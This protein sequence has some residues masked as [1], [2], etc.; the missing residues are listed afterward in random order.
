MNKFIP[1][2]FGMVTL[3]MACGQSSA[4]PSL[5]G[6]WAIVDMTPAYYAEDTIRTVR[7]AIALFVLRDSLGPKLV[8]ITATDMVLSASSG[9]SDTLQYTLADTGGGQ[10]TLQTTQGSGMFVTNARDQAT[11]TIAGSTFHLKRRGGSPE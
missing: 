10:Y 6:T 1:I 7:D 11:L 4:P 3:F 9:D 5:Q 2:G 8:T